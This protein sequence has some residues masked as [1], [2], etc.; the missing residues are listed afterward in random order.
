MEYNIYRAAHWASQELVLHVWVPAE[1]R[2][3]VAD[4]VFA[5]PS[6]ATVASVY[7]FRK[8]PNTFIVLK[9]AFASETAMEYSVRAT[10]ESFYANKRTQPR[11]TM[12]QPQAFYT[13]DN[14]EWGG[15]P[16]IVLCARRADRVD[17]LHALDPIMFTEIDAV[18]PFLIT[19]PGRI[20]L[21]VS[22]LYAYSD[23]L[24]DVVYLLD[25]LAEEKS[26]D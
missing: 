21:R 7:M 23:V 2:D 18:E 11:H 1:D 15:K 6:V 26:N 9:T 10:V 13:I 12:A 16:A 25:K 20:V 5:L 22:P 19:A 24:D 3:A 17:I 14:D 4:A 8:D